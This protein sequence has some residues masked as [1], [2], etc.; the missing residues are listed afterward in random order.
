MLQRNAGGQQAPLLAAAG[1][2]VTSLDNSEEQLALDRQVAE[3]EGL[4]LKTVLG[5]MRDLSTFDDA[6]FDL[7]VHVCSNTFVPEIDPVWK[8]CHRVLRRGGELLS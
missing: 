7:I 5:D 6:S 8:E 2:I 4:E 3:R 1:A